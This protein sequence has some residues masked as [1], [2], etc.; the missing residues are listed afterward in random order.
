MDELGA[1]NFVRS[2]RSDFCFC[3]GIR[4]LAWRFRIVGVPGGLKCYCFL[5]EI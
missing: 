5:Q 1:V 4:F 3:S 2:C